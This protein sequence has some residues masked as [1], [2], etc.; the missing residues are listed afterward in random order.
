MV[1]NISFHLSIFFKLPNFQQRT[2]TQ[3]AGA[4]MFI[5]ALFEMEKKMETI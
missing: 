1:G 3:A 5:V 4:G 2:L